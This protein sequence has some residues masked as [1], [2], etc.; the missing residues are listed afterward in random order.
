MILHPS[1]LALLV[2]SLLISLVTL[3]ACG[4]GV[5][6]LR[7]WDITNGSEL[8]LGLERSTY[9]ITT[10][11]RYLLAFQS[12]SL[13][14]YLRTAD[15]IYPLFTGAMC[16]AGALSAHWLGYPVLLLK[17]TSFFLGGI[18]LILN[19]A[20]EQG[21]DYPLIRPKYL[22]LLLMAPLIMIETVAQ[23]AYFA[24]LR[25]DTITSCCG[26]LFNS[27][28]SGIGPGVASPP[29]LPMLALFYTSASVTV[30]AGV[31][32]CMRKRGGYLFAGMSA[33]HLVITLVAVVSVISLYFYEL[34]SHHCP[35]CLLQREYGYAGYPLYLVIL[36][37]ALSG[38]GVGVLH[39]FRHCT[40]LRELLPTLQHR[41][42]LIALTAL[43][44]CSG[45]VTWKI[46]ASSLRLGG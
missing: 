22:L 44:I 6:I 5:L 19:H 17:L 13:F 24:G 41:L 10:M 37:A 38:I 33:A 20:D 25:P 30:A 18:W 1:I 28:A 39:P 36:A 21:Y 3:Y 34:P 27:S 8:Q 14:L 4:Y 45:A 43:L 11:V 35:F 40:S 29:P 16:A 31:R 42:A 7:R 26:S 32:F 23:A 12:V 9:L 46:L 15:S 2:S